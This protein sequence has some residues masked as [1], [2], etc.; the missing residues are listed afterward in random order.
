MAQRVIIAISLACDPEIVI[1]DDAESIDFSQL[2]IRVLG[3]NSLGLILPW[4]NF[5]CSFSPVAAKPGKIAFISQ[6]AAVCTTVLDW[7]NDKNIGFSSFIFSSTDI[8]VALRRYWR[9]F[10]TFFCYK[11]L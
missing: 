6:S 7:A 4:H 2:N 1:S 3:P 10:K 5:N 9:I 11:S 8:N